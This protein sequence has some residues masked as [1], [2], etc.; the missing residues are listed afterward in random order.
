MPEPKTNI[1]KN[2]SYLTAALI[3][4]KILSLTYFTFLARELGPENLGQYY[5]A[6]SFATVFSII[7]D[8]GLANVL[9]REVAKKQDEAKKLLGNV[10]GLKIP[11]A[12]ITIIA[13]LS[14]IGFNN[15][16]GLMRNLI[17]VSLACVIMDSFTAT[18]Y[19]V[20]R[21]FHNL[22]YESIS[23]ALFHTIVISIGL[24]L[25]FWKA[26]LVSQMMALLAA[27]TFQF[28]FSFF[29]IWKKIKVPIIPAWD[30]KI[31]KEII[32][33]GVPFAGFVIFQRLFTYLD[34]VM[35]GHFADARYVGY[36]QISFRIVFALQFIPA[37][38]TAAVYPAMSAFWATNR[39][40]LKIT[41]EKSMIYL[42]LLA[43]PISAGVIALADKIVL[44]FKSGYGEAVLPMRII[45][46]SV[47]FIFI[48]YP[49]GSLLN[50]CD[51]QKQNTIN[52]I[53]VSVLSIVANLILIPRFQ[54]VGAAVT[55]L[56]ANALMVILGFYQSKK[57]ATFN[58]KKVFGTWFKIAISSAIIGTTAFFLKERINIFLDIAICIISYPILILLFQVVKKDEILH[59]KNSFLAK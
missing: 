23:S 42:A 53:I 17:L 6:I 5:L 45:I 19:A 22:K 47:F 21:G 33:I 57:I 7:A 36:Y 25:L 50:A 39:E 52:M 9:T 24:P 37:A 13:V 32:L 56:A 41:F 55:V 26:G 28:I 3:F 16:S 35:L 4:Q 59:I 43:L 30:K 8:L 12:I 34:S 10:L 1:T 46:F 15:Y 40:Q 48:G 29:I 20:S 51:R 14:A 27:S 31:L 38:F 44:I 18:F 2:T 54:A 58:Y 49:L 11:L